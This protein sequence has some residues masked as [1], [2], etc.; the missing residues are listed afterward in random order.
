MGSTLKGIFSVGFGYSML[1][2]TTPILFA[3][4]GAVVSEKAGAV[5][6]GLE[7]LMLISGVTGVI[8]SAWTQSA[9][10]GLLAGL[11][12]AVLFAL[13]MGYFHI[14]LGTDMVLAGIAMNVIAS[15]GTVF[16]LFV[17]SGDRGISSSLASKV[18]PTVEL[19]LIN[20]IPVIGP[21]L[22]GHNVLTYFALLAVVG[23]WYF[24]YRT[25]LGLRLR[26]VGE[27]P[28][29][30]DSVGISVSKMRFLALGISGFLAGFG[31]CHLSM[32]YV[33]WFSRDMTAG[34][35]FIGLAASA[36]GG[37]HPIGTAIASLFFGFADALSNY[38][39]SLS[40][41]S[42]FVQMIPYLATVAALGV[43]ARR[44]MSRERKGKKQAG[45]EVA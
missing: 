28:D 36:L 1:R 38:M 5:N 45:R 24:L 8:V 15:G 27:S 10:L 17:A 3:A 22:S 21:I 25:P 16:A 44:Q 19:P 9:W 35:G 33:S 43:F 7:G 13:F 30:A 11:V 18:L 39:Q 29:S 34:R 40:I 14:K 6:I 32:G 26:A 2:V 37:V 20:K 23:V 31:G 12:L 41:P 4:L 42:E